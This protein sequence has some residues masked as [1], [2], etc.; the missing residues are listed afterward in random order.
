MGEHASACRDFDESLRGLRQALMVAS[1]ATPPRDPGKGAFNDPATLPPDAVFWFWM[2][3]IVF[4]SHH[5]L[6]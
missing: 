6:V 5:V 2:F 1:E 3:A 4:S